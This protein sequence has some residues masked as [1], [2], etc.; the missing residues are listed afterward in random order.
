M[1]AKSVQS[2]RRSRSTISGA[3][4]F[5]GDLRKP[6]I[7]VYYG[8][9]DGKNQFGDTVLNPAGIDLTLAVKRCLRMEGN[10]VVM[11]FTRDWSGK[12]LP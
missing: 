7:Q 11:M 12:V 8:Y 5:Q 3:I 6:V 2:K 4:V 1:S 10:D 9:N